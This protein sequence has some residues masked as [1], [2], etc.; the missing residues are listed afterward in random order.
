MHHI[1]RLLALLTI[2]LIAQPTTAETDWGEHNGRFCG[3]AQTGNWET[4]T[5][6][7]E[8]RANVSVLAA[9][10]LVQCDLSPGN[11]DAYRVTYYMLVLGSA[12]TREKLLRAC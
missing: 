2:A 1:A 4:I 9:L 10:A 5:S 11:S 7:A 3:A 12:Q 8:R 6:Y